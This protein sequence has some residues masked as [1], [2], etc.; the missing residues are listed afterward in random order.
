MALPPNLSALYSPGR[1]NSHSTT[2][3]GTSMRGSVICMSP[4]LANAVPACR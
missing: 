4:F 1:N 2:L 3:I